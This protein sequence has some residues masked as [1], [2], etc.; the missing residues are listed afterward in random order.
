[1]QTDKGKEFLNRHFQDFLK[2]KGIRHFIFH[3]HEETKACIVEQFNRTLKTRMW[4]YFTKC[5]TL[6]Y[7]DVLQHLVDS[8]NVSYHRSEHRQP[9]RGVAA[10]VRKRKSQ[11]NRTWFK[12]RRPRSYHKAKRQFKNYYLPNLIDEIFTVKT[13]R[14]TD[15]PVSRLIDDQGSRVEHTFYEQELQKVGVTK[16]KVYRIE[17]V[18]QWRKHGRQI[19]VVVKWLYYPES[20]NSWMDE[21]SLVAYEGGRTSLVRPFLL[22]TLRRWCSSRRHRRRHRKY[23]QNVVWKFMSQSRNRLLLSS[24]LTVHC[25]CGQY[26]Q[27]N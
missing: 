15:P 6:M 9:R 16:D 27:P 25:G 26:L 11:H 24:R 23:Q 18:L 8:Y 7:L 14:R 3:T 13:V 12:S 20:F 22:W 4:R 17:K 19:Q 1:M 2:E 10:I 5:Q 21:S